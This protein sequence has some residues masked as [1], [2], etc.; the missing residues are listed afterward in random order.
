MP[1]Y[2]TPEGKLIAWYEKN[3]IEKYRPI[4]SNLLI[5]KY[6]KGPFSQAQITETL[7]YTLN[8]YQEQF[9]SLLQNENQ[10]TFYLGLFLLHEFSCDFHMENPNNSPIEQIDNL[11]FAVYRRILK[12][13]LEQACDLKLTMG[14]TSSIE[15][16]KSKENTID[17]LLYLGD[18]IFTCSNLLAEQQ[19]I[20]DCIDLKFTLKKSVLF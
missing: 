9:L 1:I 19:L 4:I 12:L 17:E 14:V 15:Y 2:C 20:E 10:H 18:F 8:W 5:V 6:S 7:F 11:E 16:L 3:T 13:C